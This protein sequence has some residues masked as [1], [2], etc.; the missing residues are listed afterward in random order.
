[1]PPAVLQGREFAGYGARVGA[2]FIDL[3]I[4]LVLAITIVGPILYLAFTMARKGE[5][6]GQTFGKQAVGIRVI[7]EDGQQWDF[8]TALLREF[9][10]KGLLFGTLGSFF[11]LIPTLVDVL[12]PLWDERKQALHDKVVGSYVVKA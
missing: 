12:F 10:V 8:G 7:R 11:L 2:W 4:T 9:V 3:L 1:M 6:N 5:N